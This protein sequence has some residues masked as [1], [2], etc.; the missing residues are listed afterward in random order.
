MEAWS[1]Q[2]NIGALIIGIG[3]WARYTITIMRDLPPKIV[4]VII[5]API[6]RVSVHRIARK[7][8]TDQLAWNSAM[9]DTICLDTRSS[10][11]TYGWLS[12]LRPFLG[13][14]NHR[15]R[16]IIGTPKIQKGTPN[17]KP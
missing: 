9:P 2:V 4:Q 16:I 1:K 15:C 11:P 14:L 7:A 12:K 17:P 8:N 13:T 3:F 10:K 6:L 5:L